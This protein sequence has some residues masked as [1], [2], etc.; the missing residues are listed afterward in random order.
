M[1]RPKKCRGVVK[2]LIR[3][4]PKSQPPNSFFPYFEQRFVFEEQDFEQTAEYIWSADAQISGIT[5]LVFDGQVLS[6]RAGFGSRSEAT[7]FIEDSRSTAD[8]ALRQ[9]RFFY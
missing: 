2:V 4:S 1:A 3:T 6:G 9:A 8:T 5:K 7:V